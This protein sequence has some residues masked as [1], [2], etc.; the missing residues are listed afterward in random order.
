M[1]TMATLATLKD[2]LKKYWGECP[3]VNT[4]TDQ[5][6]NIF[7]SLTRGVAMVATVAIDDRTRSCHLRPHSYGFT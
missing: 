1:A 4:P 6:E 3:I 5:L 7:G 2:F